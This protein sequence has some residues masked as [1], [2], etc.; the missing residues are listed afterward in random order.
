MNRFFN[1]VLV[2]AEDEAVRRNRLGLLQRV[3]ALSE[4]IADLSGLEGF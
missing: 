4:G 2:M 1:E 3:A